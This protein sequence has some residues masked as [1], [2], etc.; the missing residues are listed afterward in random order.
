MQ[1]N[2]SRPKVLIVT[3]KLDDW[4]QR[5]VAEAEAEGM[6]VLNGWDD[7]LLE[8]ACVSVT[9]PD[10]GCLVRSAARPEGEALMIFN[11]AME[12]AEFSFDSP[13]QW[14]EIAADQMIPELFPV[15]RKGTSCSM[16]IPAGALR[17]FIRNRPL[18]PAPRKLPT[19][20]VEWHLAK[21]EKLCMSA[22]RPT[23]LR[24]VK[25]D[26]SLFRNGLWQEPDFSGIIT[27]TAEVEAAEAGSAYVR[28]RQICHAGILS[29]NG[30]HCG[31]QVAAP[32]AFKVDL[33]AGKNRLK[34][35]IASSAG[36]EWR[37]C[38]R[39]E[40]EPRQWV[41]CYLPTIRNF[42]MTDAETGIIPW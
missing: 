32:W 36:N 3:S 22:E 19:L 11:P 25:A 12:E 37:R 14:G 18:L 21:V 5:L 20:D 13:A 27:L 29:V 28:F 23:G 39:E 15:T 33:K 1:E 38:I 16:T 8:F 26:S 4:E 6:T 7:S 35:Q 2:P 17:I 41:N 40:L 10:S 34:L 9:A 42:A 30:R 24:R 31:T